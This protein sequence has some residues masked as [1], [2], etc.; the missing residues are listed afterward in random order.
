MSADCQLLV[1]ANFS[2]EEV[3]RLLTASFAND[4][5]YVYLGGS[6]RQRQRLIRSLLRFHRLQQGLDIQ[7]VRN[8]ELV[9]VA[10]VQR[11]GL[12]IP[13]GR[14]V[15]HLAPLLFRFDVAALIKLGRYH[16]LTARHRPSAPHDYLFTMAV[17]PAEQGK[18]Y[19]KALLE[20][21]HRHS[22]A[23]STSCGVA[24]DTENPD[25]L[26]WY[27]HFGYTVTARSRL[28]AVSIWHLFRSKEKN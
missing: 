13:L 8:G 16:R 25:N 28:G 18:G 27:E 20:E 9:G 7:A 17:A 21:V 4:P 1:G 3:M 22:A 15:R 5:L 6:P 19:G 11:G 24:L 10:L 23:N 2:L 12:S 26:G 14:V